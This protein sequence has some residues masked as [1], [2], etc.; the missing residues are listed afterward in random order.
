[1]E[2]PQ[3]MHARF[4]PLALAWALLAGCAATPAKTEPAAPLSLETCPTV[5]APVDV[6]ALDA[7]HKTLADMIR[8]GEQAEARLAYTQCEYRNTSRKDDYQVKV[9]QALKADLLS[10]QQGF[11][12]WQEADAALNKHLAD[13]YGRCLGLHLSTDQYQACK[14]EN[15]ALNAERK[16]VNDASLP[17]QQ[18]A[19]DLDARNAK[20]SADINALM[21]ES[22][23]TGEAYPRALQTHARW[24]AQAYVLMISPELKPYAEKNGCPDIAAPPEDADTLLSLGADV[25]ACFKKT[26]G[27]G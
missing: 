23:R 25:L 7:G 19:E 27:A 24:L 3:P 12:R 5:A 2:D 9:G 6:A 4:L 1:M 13:Y 16:R 21:Q 20:Y 22:V 11:D 17:L 8:L 26:A 18:R 15:D 10:Y 14:D